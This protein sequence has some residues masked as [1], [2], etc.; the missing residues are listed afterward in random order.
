MN[1]NDFDTY[2]KFEPNL[3]KANSSTPCFDYGYDIYFDT[4]THKAGSISIDV[5]LYTKKQ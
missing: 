4:E 5:D 2:K 1:P 3:T